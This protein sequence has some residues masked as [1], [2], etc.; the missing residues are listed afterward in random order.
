MPT[1]RE[2]HEGQK[3]RM[4]IGAFECNPMWGTSRQTDYAQWKKGWLGSPAD[5][6]L[7]VSEDNAKKI[8][9]GLKIK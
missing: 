9:E 7:G 6:F 2:T 1:F 5:K 3:T 4:V 8:V